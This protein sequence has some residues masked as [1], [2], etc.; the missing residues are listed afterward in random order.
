MLPLPLNL[1]PVL[2]QSQ[3]WKSRRDDNE[4]PEAKQSQHFQKANIEEL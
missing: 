1:A 2:G 4:K 3:A